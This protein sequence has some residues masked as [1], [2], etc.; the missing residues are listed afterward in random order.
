MI[1]K[2]REKVGVC[3]LNVW[4]RNH[5]YFYACVCDY[6]LNVQSCRFLF[7]I[8]VRQEM[9]EY[10]VLF[11]LPREKGGEGERERGRK[12]KTTRKRE[13]E[14]ERMCFKVRNYRFS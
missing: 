13:R 10:E 5:V 9:I 3:Y 4:I 6:F 1:E 14:G 2:E 8:C 12:R 11:I 7:I